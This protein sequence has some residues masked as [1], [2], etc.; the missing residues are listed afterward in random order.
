MS[1]LNTRDEL[2]R[3]KIRVLQ[4]LSHLEHAP[5]VQMNEIPPDFFLTE[6]YEEIDPDI[7]IS[8][9]EQDRMINKENEY[10]EDE[11]DQEA[12]DKTKRSSKNRQEPDIYENALAMA[13][14]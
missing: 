9:S 12:E 3:T 4:N 5:S 14:D 7:R 13:E 10:F 11:F 1:N 6:E 2:E 8:Q